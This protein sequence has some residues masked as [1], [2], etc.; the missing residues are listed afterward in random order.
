M[1]PKGLMALALLLFVLLLPGCQKEEEA[2]LEPGEPVVWA[3]AALEWA[4]RQE[5]D[6]PTGTVTTSDLDKLRM[7]SVRSQMIQLNNGN[8]YRFEKGEDVQTL[9]DLR[10]FRRLIGVQVTY[11]QLSDLSVLSQ[12]Q[13]LQHLHLIENPNVEDISPISGLP[14]LSQL[15]MYGNPVTDLDPIRTLEALTD[16]DLRR[17]NLQTLRMEEGFPKLRKLRLEGNRLT[18]ISFLEDVPYLT[19]LYLA[20]NYISDITPLQGMSKLQKLDLSNNRIEDLSPL[21]DRDY[22][23]LAMLDV[24]LNQISDLSPVIGK[25][26][27]STLQFAGNQ[28]SDVS[29][30]AGLP[31][32]RVLNGADNQ[33]VD[34]APLKKLTKMKE[35]NLSGNI[36]QSIDPI[37]KM[38]KLNKL[39]LTDCAV[40]K[41]EIKALE[42]ALKQ[43]KITY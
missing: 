8:I 11:T 6:I 35:L 10:H 27:L 14:K 34:I 25:K 28:V 5:L 20:G 43:C 29:P 16:L 39:N 40:G 38:R 1:R 24:S 23:D 19:E 7:V 42:K 30:L 3:D 36:I 41:N 13:E 9:D 22:P 18:D 31:E 21:A 4:V 33:I 26:R 17:S 37:K 12:C 32:M 2:V 15:V